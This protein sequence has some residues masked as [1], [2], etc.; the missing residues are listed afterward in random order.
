[1]SRSSVLSPSNS[2]H[3]VRFGFGDLVVVK[4]ASLDVLPLVRVHHGYVQ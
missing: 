3:L 2:A 4:Y 1:M